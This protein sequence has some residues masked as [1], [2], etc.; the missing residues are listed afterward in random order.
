MY[1]YIYVYMYANPKRMKK[2]PDTK[3]IARYLKR[4]LKNMV[5]G[6]AGPLFRYLAMSLVSGTF[7]RAFRIGCSAKRFNG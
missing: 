5:Y 3:D 2:V 1:I 7:F 6:F 4:G